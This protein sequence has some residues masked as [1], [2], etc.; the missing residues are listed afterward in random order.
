MGRAINYLYIKVYDYLPHRFVEYNGVRVPEKKLWEEKIP[1]RSPKNEDYEQGIVNS[2]REQ[3]KKGD[4]VT[5]LGGGIGVT[6]VIA[7]EETSPQ[8]VK[9][10]EASAEQLEKIKLTLE[11]NG[12]EEVELRHALVG[13]EVDVWG[14]S[15]SA[16]RVDPSE[17]EECDVLEMD[18]EGSEKQVLK[19]LDIRPRVIIVES[20]GHLDCSTQEVKELL[21]DLSYRIENVELAEDVEHARNNDIKVV[22]GAREVKN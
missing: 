10:F 21:R 6:A 13:P 15:E 18:I 2:I 19:E 12:C 1:T 5:I 11:E 16:D 4:E 9:V 7:S 20:H 8:N 14:S 22:T 3:V 17:L